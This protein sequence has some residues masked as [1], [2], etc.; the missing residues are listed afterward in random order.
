MRELGRS[1]RPRQWE[2]HLFS[3]LPDYPSCRSGLAD[4]FHKLLK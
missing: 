3:I 1:A 4:F 2:K